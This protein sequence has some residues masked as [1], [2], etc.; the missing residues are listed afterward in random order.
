LIYLDTSLVVSLFCLDANSAAAA[1]L[2]QTAEEKFLITVL[3][4][5]EA[6]NAF[7]L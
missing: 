6:V 3:V 4:E 2:L 1:T 7:G 5:L